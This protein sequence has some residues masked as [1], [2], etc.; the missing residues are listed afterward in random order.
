MCIRDSAL[1]LDL[2]QYLVYSEVPYVGNLLAIPK[3]TVEASS[4]SIMVHVDAICWNSATISA[5]FRYVNKLDSDYWREQQRWE[6]RVLSSLGRFIPSNFCCA[7]NMT[8]VAR[9]PLLVRIQ[10]FYSALEVPQGFL[11]EQERRSLT[12]LEL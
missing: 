3:Q 6:R 9:D 12:A 5:L 11:F 10:A 7:Y 1:G 2:W 4:G 8:K